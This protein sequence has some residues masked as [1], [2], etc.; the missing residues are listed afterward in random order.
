LTGPDPLDPVQIDANMLSHPD[1]M[2][3]AIAGVQLSREVGYAEALRPFAKGEVM[4]SNVKGAQLERFVRDAAMSYWHQTCAAKMGQDAMSVVDAALKVYGIE[5]LRTADG[6]IM[7]GVTTG[8]T[9]APYDIIGER[10]ADI[11]ESQHAL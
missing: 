7:P 9:M 2:K 10:A 11:L 4:P 3:S 1:D 8:N 5:R 6:S